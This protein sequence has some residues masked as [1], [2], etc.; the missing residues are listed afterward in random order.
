MVMEW[1]VGINRQPIIVHRVWC[2]RLG[3]TRSS[4]RLAEVQEL[5]VYIVYSSSTYRGQNG[6]E[7]PALGVLQFLRGGHSG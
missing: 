5:C 4:Q 7:W 2:F 1:A 6:H 3:T